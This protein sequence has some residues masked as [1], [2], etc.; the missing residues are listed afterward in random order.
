MLGSPRKRIAATL[1]GVLVVVG[2]I[3]GG[4]YLLNGPL[5]FTSCSGVLGCG[6]I[7]PLA[8]VLVIAAVIGFLSGQAPKY[9]DRQHG[10]AAET[11]VCES[12]GNPVMPGWRL[13]PACGRR[14]EGASAR[15]DDAGVS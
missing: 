6:W 12:C 4:A 8:A 2:V 5:G 15:V 7:V 13:C 1:L 3:L 9:D 14:L 11:A 10:E